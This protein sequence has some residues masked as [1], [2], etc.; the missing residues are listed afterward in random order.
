M[1]VPQRIVQ[2]MLGHAGANT[3]AIYARLSDTTLRREFERYQHERVNIRVS[4]SPWGSRCSGAE[5]AVGEARHGEHP[6]ARS[7]R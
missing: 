5:M 6:P 7:R 2:Q 3:V 1:G 4:S